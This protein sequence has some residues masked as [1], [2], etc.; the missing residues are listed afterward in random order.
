MYSIL[1]DKLVDKYGKQYNIGDK[2][3]VKIIKLDYE[4]LEIISEV[5]I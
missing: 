1:E 5:D 3:N 4:K 2:I